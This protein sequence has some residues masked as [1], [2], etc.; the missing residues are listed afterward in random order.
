MDSIQIY[1]DC[2]NMENSPHKPIIYFWET[3]LIVENTHS[4]LYVYSLLIKSNIQGTFF[5]C[6]EIIS[7]PQSIEFMDFMINV[8]YQ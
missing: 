1:S 7:A 3:M 5:Y 2:F 8:I 4:K 6:E